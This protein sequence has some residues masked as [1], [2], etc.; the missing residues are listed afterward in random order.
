[1]IKLLIPLARPSIDH[2]S[3][4]SNMDLVNKFEIGFSKRYC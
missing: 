1:M 4:P 2:Q 3:I